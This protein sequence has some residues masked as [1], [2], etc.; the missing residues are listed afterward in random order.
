MRLHDDF[1]WDH[2]RAMANREKHRVTFEIAAVVLADKDG[3]VHH[4]EEYDDSHSYREDR[5]TTTCSHPD[6]RSVILRVSWTDRPS[7]GGHL[8]RII[9][10]RLATA[11]ERKLY[12]K[13]IAI[14]LAGR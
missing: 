13:E 14:R 5:Y 6:D 10:A 8:T 3:D 4:L 12:A 11:R 2:A 9:S 7:V 1:E